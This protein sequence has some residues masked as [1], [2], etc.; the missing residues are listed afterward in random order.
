MEIIVLSI[1]GLVWEVIYYGEV[2]IDRFYL[3]FYLLYLSRIGDVCRMYYVY[4][5]NYNIVY[6]R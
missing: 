6:K 5:V 2:I 3:L 1:I 4:L